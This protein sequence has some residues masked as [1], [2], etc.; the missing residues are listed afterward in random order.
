M[1]W[2]IQWS[3]QLREDELPPELVVTDGDGSVQ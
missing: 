3:R 1:S 2:Y